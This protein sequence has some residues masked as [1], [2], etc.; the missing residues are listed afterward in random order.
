MARARK[1]TTTSETLEEIATLRVV[2]VDSQPPIWRELEVPASLTLQRLNDVLQ[3]AFG[4]LDYHLWEFE[5]DGT[6]YGRPIED[7]PEVV[8]AKKVILRDVFEGK[9]TKISY[10]YDFG[11]YWEHQIK[12][13]R[14]HA[15]EPDLSYPRLIGGEM[16]G[17]LED[18]GGLPGYYALLEARDDP[19]H[20]DHEDAVEIV[21][22]Y[23]P[24]NV[25]HQ[26]IAA[27]LGRISRQ[28]SAARARIKKAE[29]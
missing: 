21:G 20:P 23:D 7:D 27:G 24:T 4:W 17:P 2:L 13:S 6:R 26:A 8:N 3:V 14:I 19:D 18:C 25:L 12:V 16:A 11:D 9:T 22:E 5:I 28:L 10:V 15:A 29:E 1:T